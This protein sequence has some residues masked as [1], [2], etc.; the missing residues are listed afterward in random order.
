MPELNLKVLNQNITNDTKALIASSEAAYKELISSVCAKIES[1]RELKIVLL[2]GPSGSGK[3]TS[4]NLLADRLISDGKAASVVSLD[5]FY[6]ESSDPE[7]PL[8]ENGKRDFETVDA[9]DI[10]L[11]QKTLA[12][13]A[14]GKEYSIPKFDFKLGGRSEMRNYPKT[15]DGIVI[16]EGLHAL[17]PR[18]FSLLP[19]E[20]LLKIFISVS[21][22]IIDRG[23]IILSGRKIRFLRRMVRD[24]IYRGSNAE[25]TLSMWAGVLK[26]EDKYLYPNRQ[27]ADIEFNTFHPYELGVMRHFAERLISQKLAEKNPYAKTVLSAVSLVEPISLS[28]VP[29]NSL[30]REFVP[31]GI[32][33]NIY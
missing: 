33:E 23:A 27:N 28:N 32:Y 11:L 17:N 29:E 14:D 13:I 25:E 22:N 16:I 18:V 31:G 12:N 5:D 1:R 9:L 15:N 20:K 8:L 21:T 30:I 19:P 10:P 3:T 2:A 7:Y 26:G 24:S 4:A 6:R